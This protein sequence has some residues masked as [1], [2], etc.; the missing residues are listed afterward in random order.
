[1]LPTKDSFIKYM[2]FIKKK[3]GDISTLNGSSL[4]LEDKFTFLGRSVSSTEKD[5]NM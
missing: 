1:M 3:K 4:K 5:I 2:C